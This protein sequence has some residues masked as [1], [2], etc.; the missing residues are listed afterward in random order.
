M[1]NSTG[2]R[3]LRNGDGGSNWEETYENLRSSTTENDLGESERDFKDL[4]LLIW[5]IMV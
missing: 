4:L 2:S 5:E 1:R 3:W